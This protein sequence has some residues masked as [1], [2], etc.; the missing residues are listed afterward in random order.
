MA[1][2]TPAYQAFNPSSAE[3]F[4]YKPW[5]RLGYI[6][7]IHLNPY[8][9]GL[10]PIEIFKFFQSRDHL[11]LFIRQILTIKTVSALEG[12]ISKPK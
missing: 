10:R 1:V 4:L 6:L 3:L 8:A 7:L 12:L 2:P 11:Y 5:R 9:T